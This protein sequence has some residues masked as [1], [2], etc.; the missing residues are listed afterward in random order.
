M[1]KKEPRVT[2]NEIK[3]VLPAV[4]M[5]VAGMNDY[6]TSIMHEVHHKRISHRRAYG[7]I[8]AKWYNYKE[9]IL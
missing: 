8:M 6:F 4:T 1:E 5:E 7:L 2:R 3:K 9:S